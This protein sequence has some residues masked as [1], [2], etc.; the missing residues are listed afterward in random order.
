M[1]SDAA[2]TI[3]LTHYRTPARA[4]MFLQGWIEGSSKDIASLFL[5]GT[6]VEL[7]DL[8]P[9]LEGNIAIPRFSPGMT[10]SKFIVNRPVTVEGRPLNVGKRVRVTTGGGEIK[11]SGA[12]RS[13]YPL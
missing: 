8:D 3:E 5:G 4:F 9:R 6:S 12:P 1:A 11:W 7:S 2:I 10:R 13:P